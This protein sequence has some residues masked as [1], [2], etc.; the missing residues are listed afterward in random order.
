MYLFGFIVYVMYCEDI[1]F[2]LKSELKLEC[3]DFDE[4]FW[5]LGLHV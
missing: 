2:F 4:D 3:W 5:V 1:V